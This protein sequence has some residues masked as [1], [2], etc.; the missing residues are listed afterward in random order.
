MSERDLIRQ[1]RAAYARGE[2]V[3]ELFRSKAGM[4][5]N[6]HDAVLVAYDLQSGS[7]RAKL[8]DPAHR[9]M[10][11]RYA[12][13]VASVLEELDYD[14]LFE[15][16]TGEATTLMPVLSA[17]QR[18]PKHVVACDLAWSRVANAR[19][20]ARDFPMPAP[21]LFAGDMF[22]LPVVDGA[23]DLVLTLHALE[24]N[25]GRELAGVAELARVSRRWVVLF[26]PSYDLG[27][28]E[29]RRRIEEH[30]YV[31]NLRG[32]AEE[33]GLEVVR[34]ELLEDLT[35]NNETAVLVLRKP[36]EPAARA[37]WLGCPRCNEPLRPTHAH[38][39]CAAEGLVYPVLDGIPCLD[40]RNAIVASAF[41]D[42][43]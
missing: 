11:D 20:H 8:D 43:L 10:I 23:F 35:P 12:R 14:S 40:P 28:P 25:G 38:L 16:G 39:F 7:Y 32:A 41:A 37:S 13:K 3:M 18:P 1:A 29:S 31:R 26:E 30:G 24:P 4:E 36:G 42:E 19:T 2:N 27:G 17:L 15:A 5:G 21:E 33:L 34:H 6:T 22:A 9:A